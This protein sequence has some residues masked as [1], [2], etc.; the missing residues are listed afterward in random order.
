[1]KV[2][3]DRLGWAGYRCTLRL[4]TSWACSL[5]TL[6]SLCRRPLASGFRLLR[7]NEDKVVLEKLE[8]FSFRESSASCFFLV[9]DILQILP[10]NQ[11]RIPITT[12]QGAYHDQGTLYTKDGIAREPFITLWIK[13]GDQFSVTEGLD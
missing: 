5:Y 1:M 12:K 7:W 10:N 4:F 13:G 2:K 3:I 6:G 11:D 8:C 9:I